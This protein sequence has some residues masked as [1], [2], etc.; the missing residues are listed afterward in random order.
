M[1]GDF[2][3]FSWRSIVCTSLPEVRRR[4]CWYDPPRIVDALV[5]LL[6]AACGGRP[7]GYGG[8]PIGTPFEPWC[9]RSWRAH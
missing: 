9:A 6:L 2:E 4:R 7:P 8:P 1:C 5:A 3:R